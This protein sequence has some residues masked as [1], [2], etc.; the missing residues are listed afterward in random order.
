MTSLDPPDEPGDLYEARGDVP[1][2]S[3]IMQGDVFAHVSLPGLSEQPLAVAIV[4]HPCS[5]RAGDQLRPKITVAAVRPYQRLLDKDWRTGHVNVMPL[6]H[7]R[8]TDDW[9]AIDFREIA[10]V[11]SVALSRRAR[12]A[13]SSRQGILLLQQRCAFHLTRLVVPLPNLYE[14]SLPVFTECELATDW[15]EAALDAQPGG[16]ED[17]TINEADKAF[18]AYLDEDDRRRRKRLQ[19]SHLHSD[20]RR[21]C[22]G[23]IAR[24]YAASESD[25]PG[26]R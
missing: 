6:P 18:H 17:T 14:V 9:Y 21:E 5:M 12:I 22:R 16:D 26:R 2:A 8:N 4:M 3:P 23:E 20:L 13:S 1:L 11:P 10:T 15:V 19:H 7:L 24:R 25:R